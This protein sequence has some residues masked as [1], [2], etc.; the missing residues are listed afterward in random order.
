MSK[1]QVGNSLNNL[2]TKG[3]G[4]LHTPVKPGS[5]MALVPVITPVPSALMINGKTLPAIDVSKMNSADIVNLINNANIP[6]VKASLDAQGVLQ[7]SGLDTLM[8]DPSLL[9]I[10]GIQGIN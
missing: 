10:L 1:N 9:A 4:Q 8:G 5:Q 2:P 3:I 7:I 6:G